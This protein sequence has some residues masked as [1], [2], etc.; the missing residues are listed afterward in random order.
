MENPQTGHLYRVCVPG[1][2]SNILPTGH[3]CTAAAAAPAMAGQGVP[4]GSRHTGIAK[5]RMA[6]D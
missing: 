4:A 1:P 2:G 3:H 6:R 5:Q